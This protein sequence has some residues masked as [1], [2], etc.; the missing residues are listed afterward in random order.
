MRAPEQSKPMEVRLSN[1]TAAKAISDA[2]RTSLGPKGMDKMVSKK[3]L[4]VYDRTPYLSFR[5]PL[6]KGRSL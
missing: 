4:V 5:S 6:Q 3:G 1:M 2:V